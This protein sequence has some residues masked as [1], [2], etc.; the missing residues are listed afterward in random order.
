MYVIDENTNTIWIKFIAK[1]TLVAFL[2]VTGIFMGLFMSNRRVLEREMLTRAQVHFNN[3]LLTRQWNA[4]YGGVFVEKKDGM[5]SN[6]Y[7][8]NPDIISVDGTIYTKKN[9]ALMT[10]EISEIAQDEKELV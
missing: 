9:P 7:L 5:I 2:F 3:I 8:E 6:P 1:I 10:R 4:Q